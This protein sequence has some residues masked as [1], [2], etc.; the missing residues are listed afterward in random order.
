MALQATPITIKHLFTHTAGSEHS[1]FDA[2]CYILCK[3]PS[4]LPSFF[5]KCKSREFGNK[6]CSVIHGYILTDC[7]CGSRL[8]PLGPSEVQYGVLVSA[9]YD[10]IDI[11]RDSADTV[12]RRKVNWGCIMSELGSL[13][14]D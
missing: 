13:S 7:F 2:F 5:G 8:A 4:F 10:R 9:I 1:Q 14:N 3:N 11:V 6:T 12:A